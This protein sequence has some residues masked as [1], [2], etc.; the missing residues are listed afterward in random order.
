MK[1]KSRVS[2]AGTH[3]RVGVIFHPWTQVDQ[4]QEEATWPGGRGWGPARSPREVWNSEGREVRHGRQELNRNQRDVH[5]LSQLCG[6]STGQV[7]DSPSTDIIKNR[8]NRKPL[9]TN[10]I[11][12][13]TQ[14]D[15]FIDG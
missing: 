6:T 5:F 15:Y 11:P 4:S 10:G 13:P 9:G 2:E 8:N 1:I 12:E 14:R 3:V 7:W